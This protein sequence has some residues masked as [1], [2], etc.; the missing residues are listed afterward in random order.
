MDEYDKQKMYMDYAIN[1]QAEYEYMEKQFE[2]RLIQ[3]FE[4]QIANAIDSNDIMKIKELSDKANLLY[5]KKYYDISLVINNTAIEIFLKHII[6]I[7]YIRGFFYDEDLA[8]ILTE[9]LLSK[10]NISKLDKL[11]IHLFQSQFKKQN[12]DIK[13]LLTDI[14]ELRT[15]RNGIIHNGEEISVDKALLAKQT[16]NKILTVMIPVIE[17]KKSKNVT[18]LI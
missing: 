7:S 11:M 13:K 4:D 5:E 12:L 10:E 2:I 6:L 15:I 14:R 9:T 1:E 8:E 16:I 17:E 3:Y 18:K